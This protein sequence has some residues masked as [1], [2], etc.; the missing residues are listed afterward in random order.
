MTPPFLLLGLPL[1]SLVEG[2]ALAVARS[3]LLRLLLLLGLLLGLLAP[4]LLLRRPT[5]MLLVTLIALMPL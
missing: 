1:R 3:G 2:E 4:L 5:S